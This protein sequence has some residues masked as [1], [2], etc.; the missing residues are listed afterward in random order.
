MK[1][2][3]IAAVANH[4]VIGHNNTLPWQMPADLQYFKKMTLNKPI[5]MGRKNY[6]SIGRPLPQRHNIIITRNKEFIAEGCSV[7]HSLKDALSLVAD[8]AEV[9]IIGGAEIYK[10]ALP[11]ADTL[12]L[13]FINA[14]I[15]GDTFFPEWGPQQWQELSRESHAADAKN[16]YAYSFVKYTRINLSY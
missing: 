5:I 10:M 15:E 8:A 6:E 12:Y 7:V 14:D 4:N 11:L 16:P 2:S 1:I 13:T 9:M 3:I